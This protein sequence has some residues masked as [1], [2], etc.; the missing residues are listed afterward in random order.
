MG[1][2]LHIRVNVEE[3]RFRQTVK[4]AGGRWNPVKLSFGIDVSLGLEDRIIIEKH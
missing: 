1:W 4:A 2:V 3:Y